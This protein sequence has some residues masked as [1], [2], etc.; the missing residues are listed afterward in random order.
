MKFTR[1]RLQGFKSFVDPTELQIEPGLTGIVG[2]NGCGKSNLVEALRWVMGETS[3]KSLRGSGMEDVIFAGTSG[4]PARNMAEVVLSIDNAERDAP[5]ALNDHDQLEVTRRIER[6]AGSAYRVN[7]KDTR[8]RDVQLLFADLSSG[9]HSP[10][11]VRQGQIGQL[12]AAKPQNR[13]MI[14]EE[15]AGISGLHGRRHE[16]ELRLRAAET[17]LTRLEDVLNELDVQLTA[18][19]KQ[20]RQAT[21]YRNLS[22]N[23]RKSEAIVLFLRW[24]EASD[25]VMESDAAFRELEQTVARLAQEN[26]TATR[27]QADA[28]EG[29]PQLREAE[30]A[31]AA[32]LHRLTVERDTL[33]AEEKRALEQAGRLEAQLEQ[34]GAD[35]AREQDGL[36]DGERELAQLIEEAETLRRAGDGHGDRLTEADGA[37]ETLT[38]SLSGAE[39]ALEAA[40]RESAD[41]QAALGALRRRRQELESRRTRLAH[42]LEKV[43]SEKTTLEADTGDSGDMTAARE[44]VETAESAIA[45]AETKAT[46]AEQARIDAQAAEAASR[47]PLQDADRAVSALKAE[48]DTLARLC[49]SADSDLWPPVVDSI[50]VEPGFEAALGAALGDDLEVPTDEAAPMH[51]A[52]LDPLDDAP[53]LPAE[54][55]PLSEVVNAPPALARRLG[56]IGVVDDREGKALQ[57]LLKPGQRL[58]SRDGDLWRWDGITIAADAP[59]PAAVRL[60]QR[61]RLAELEGELEAAQTT[62][63][64]TREAHHAARQAAEDAGQAERAARQSLRESQSALNTAR[65]KLTEIE[66]SSSRHQQR[67]AALAEAQ[68]RL[69]SETA[70]IE[71]HLAEALSAVEDAEAK[72]DPSLALAE[73]KEKVAGLRVELTEAR[74]ALEA[75]KRDAQ[76]REAR[77]AAIEKTQDGWEAR[78]ANTASQLENLAKRRAEASGELESVRLIPDQIA[79]KRSGLIEALEAAESKRRLTANNL[80]EAEN[81]LREADASAKKLQGELSQAREDRARQEATIQGLQ[82]RVEDVAGRIREALDCNPEN[83]LEAGGVPESEELPPLDDIER[84]LDRYRRERENMGAVNLRADEEAQEY[85]ERLDAM[86]AEREDLLQAIARLRQG[87]NSLNKEGRERLL[88]AFD[89]VNSN[90]T[91]LFTE[92][93]GGGTA[94]LELVESDDPLEAGLDIFARPPGKKLTNLSLLSGGEQALTAMSLIFAVFLA[95]PAPICVLDEVDAPLDDANV[96]RFCNLLDQMTKETNTRFLVITHHALTM[97]RLDRLYGVTMAERGVSQLVSVDLQE[98]ERVIAAQ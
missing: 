84:K 18:L 98:A 52:T 93:F 60:S 35:I 16:A 10:A 47:E 44:A 65:A 25:A 89:V 68:Q 69:S 45:E 19:K 73:H 55:R 15:A 38:G 48:R 97:S 86:N 21:R 70:E 50:T 83:V 3:A 29:L 54:A 76:T 72:P 66:K 14:L 92:L 5:A 32:A 8:A 51:W 79:Q 49:Q 64:E 87:I 30:A 94:H 7:G 31:A 6:D 41:H 74:A 22:D 80:Q 34:V 61:N 11:L 36:S 20:A 27:L 17:N 57:A 12:I 46:H 95:N 85:T 42:D 58:V 59:T 13:R 26:A 53:T 78:K 9:A 24:K 77:L 43:T 23:I 1:L 71:S 82:A 91:K 56:Q 62:A 33:D 40:T 39:E 37:V 96:E 28:S 75:L 81:K 63:R 67:L 88:A 90:F 2:P 4:R